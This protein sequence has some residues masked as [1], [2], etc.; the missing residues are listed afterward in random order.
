MKSLKNIFHFQPR[1]VTIYSETYD[2]RTSA[3]RCFRRQNILT[4][5]SEF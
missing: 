3:Y 4:D 1:C 5:I 2:V